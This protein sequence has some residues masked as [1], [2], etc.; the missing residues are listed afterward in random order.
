MTGSGG[1]RTA[2]T[3]KDESFFRVSAGISFGVSPVI[4]GG[5]EEEEIGGPSI[6]PVAKDC[7]A[8]KLRVA[9]D[10][11]IMAR[12][13]MRRRWCRP[14]QD[15]RPPFEAERSHARPGLDVASSPEMSS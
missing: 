7:P 9:A 3:P 5:E 2:E 11:T 15:L 1:S 4:G 14:A 6:L 8:R 12:Q 13:E 10:M